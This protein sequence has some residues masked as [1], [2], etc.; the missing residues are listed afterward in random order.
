MLD[1]HER[2]APKEPLKSKNPIQIIRKCC[3]YNVKDVQALKSINSCDDIRRVEQNLWLTWKDQD[4]M[5]QIDFPATWKQT[6]RESRFDGNDM[7]LGIDDSSFMTLNMDYT[8]F[9]SLTEVLDS[10]LAQISYPILV[11]IYK[12]SSVRI[13]IS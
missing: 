7:T 11:R 1:A 3:T 9:T 10:A 2:V 4:K 8:S 12:S 5:F 13:I 6:A